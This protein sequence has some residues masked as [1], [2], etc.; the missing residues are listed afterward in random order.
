MFFART[1]LPIQSQI[2]PLSSPYFSQIGM[3]LDPISDSYSFICKWNVCAAD[4]VL[5]VM[6]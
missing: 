4:A 1:S 6:E 2:L 3:C 5:F